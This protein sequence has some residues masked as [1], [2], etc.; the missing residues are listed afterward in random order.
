MAFS[1]VQRRSSRHASMEANV[2][3]S[4]LNASIF[5]EDDM[6]DNYARSIAADEAT[7]AQSV[8]EDDS[9]NLSE[10]G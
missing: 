8:H 7:K 5:R 1:G 9:T 3:I 10:S 4:E 6:V 2:W